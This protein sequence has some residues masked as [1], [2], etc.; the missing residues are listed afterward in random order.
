LTSQA[1]SALRTAWLSAAR[2]L[3]RRW[4]PIVIFELL[5]ILLGALVTTP[6]ASFLLDAI[7]RSNGTVAVNNFDLVGF[8]LSPRG[9]VYLGVFAVSVLAVFF[10]LHA[11][12]VLLTGDL[13]GWRT[14]FATLRQVTMKLPALVCLGFLQVGGLLLALLPFAGPLAVVAL[15]LLRGHDINYYLHES[16]PEWRRALVLLGAAGAGY[17]AL[18]SWLLA[19]WSLSVPVLLRGASP[20]QAL[21]E[22]WRETRGK[23][24]RIVALIS[25]WWLSIVLLQLLATALLGAI[26]HPLAER[27]GINLVAGLA[28]AAAVL[29]L[30]LLISWIGLLAGHAGH[31]ILINTLYRDASGQRSEAT[32]SRGAEAPLSPATVGGAALLMFAVTAAFGIWWVDRLQFHEDL[33]VTGHRGSGAA[34]ENSL[35]AIRQAI[36]AGADYA[37][38]D[39]QRTRD[40]AVIVLHDRDLMRMAGD[41]RRV[42]DLTLAEIETLD[43]GRRKAPAFAGEHVPTL[44]QVI[45]TCRGRLKL[46]IELKYNRPDVLLAPAVI[47]IVRAN[48]F[49]D[50]VIITSLD[51][52][53]LLDVKRLAPELHTGMIV[54]KAVGTPAKLPVDFL[55]VNQAAATPA[56]IERA[57]Q[58]GKEIQVWTVNT[59]DDMT[60]M[61]ELGADNLITDNPGEAV[62]VL[63][64]R[65][66]MPSAEKVALRLRRSLAQ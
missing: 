1:T 54:T 44:Q 33:H 8:F 57:H 31:A 41:P 12:L 49:T 43:I 18:A 42:A 55:S 11:G 15:P 7:L 13:D 38:I 51:Y 65:A 46:N 59:R 32:E 9:L 21:L 52:S 28:L 20:I 50:Q 5:A 30:S 17:L 45:D 14:P 6:I 61:I 37:E 27:A 48:N 63:H 19:R 62:A 64:D 58:Q 25:G 22:S 60:R 34:P 66:A 24:W 40:G 4:Q 36:S 35:T 16:P 3:R 53:A 39:V 2:E 26:A 47:G 10:P 29:S 56:L 23:S